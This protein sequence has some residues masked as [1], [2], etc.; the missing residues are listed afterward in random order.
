MPMVRIEQGRTAEVAI[1]GIDKTID[2]M[3]KTAVILSLRGDF[4]GRNGCRIV[5]NRLY[6]YRLVNERLQRSKP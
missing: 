1:D 4:L 2:G 5:T 6:F 3:I